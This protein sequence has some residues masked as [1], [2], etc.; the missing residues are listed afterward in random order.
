MVVAK[1]YTT[2]GTEKKLLSDAMVAIKTKHVLKKRQR[3]TTIVEEDIPEG[4]VICI[5]EQKDVS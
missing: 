5:D 2:R 4:Q 1:S 3:N